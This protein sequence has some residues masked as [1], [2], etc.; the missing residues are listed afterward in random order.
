VW[1]RSY[2]EWRSWASFYRIGV[3]WHQSVTPL[4]LQEPECEVL[5]FVMEN[6]GTHWMPP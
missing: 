3:V 1:L 4:L 2:L 5:K 6:G